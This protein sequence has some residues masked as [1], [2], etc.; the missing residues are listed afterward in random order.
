M[1]NVTLNCLTH[2]VTRKFQLPARFTF[3]ELHYVIQ[4][5]FGWEGD[6]YYDFRIGKTSI[7][8]DRAHRVNIAPETSGVASTIR[9][10]D[11]LKAGKRLKYIY[12]FDANWEHNISVLRDEETDGE[13]TILL[14]SG[15]GGTPPE[16]S[17]GPHTFFATMQ[18]DGSKEVEQLNT[19]IKKSENALK[20]MKGK[21]II[22]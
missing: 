5:V 22:L 4:K 2:R 21:N 9:I 14:L 3:R 17:G 15:K 12:D 18:E 10:G 20:A 11:V 6:H 13:E 8:D 19:I 16:S 1:L 7:M